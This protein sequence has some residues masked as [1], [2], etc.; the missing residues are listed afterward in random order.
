MNI[1]FWRLTAALSKR[2]PLLRLFLW[3]SLVV[4]STEGVLTRPK[5]YSPRNAT[6][7][8]SAAR[9]YFKVIDGDLYELDSENATIGVL[10]SAASN[11]VPPTDDRQ[12]DVWEYV[13]NMESYKV[14]ELY[15]GAEPTLTNLHY[16]VLPI[17]WSNED[18]SDT[19]VQF[20]PNQ[21]DGVMQQNKDQYLDMS[22]NHMT[23]TWEQMAQTPFPISDVNPQ[24]GDMA[25]AGR[26]IVE[27]AGFVQGVDYDAISLIY[28]PAQAGNAGGGG[29]AS[30][31]GD[32]MWMSYEMN[33]LVTR[34]EVGAKKGGQWCS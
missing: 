10:S 21:I 27:D 28:N 34:H 15:S 14:S 4:V 1:I 22:W 26:Q 25:E 23:V 20:D 18:P 17:F 29:W 16:L 3:M 19:N 12:K 8:D 5:V 30:V 24:L 32:F 13:E 33:F 11:I 9:T 7:V 6:T 31:N 2:M